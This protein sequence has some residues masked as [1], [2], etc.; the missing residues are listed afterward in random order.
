MEKRMEKLI[1]KENLDNII[2]KLKSENKKIVFTNGCFDILH[3]GH[4]RYLKESKKFG[5]IL[6]V[7]LNSD[8]SV[9]KIK[10]ES[11]PINPEMDRAEVLAGLEAVSY[12]VLFDETSPVKLLEEIKPDIYTKGAD[13]TVETLPEAKTVL[14]YGG[15]IE[16]IKFLEGRSTTK[17]I[18]KIK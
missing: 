3:A 13:Y 5:D 14:S 4:V 1:E 16:F 18:D 7:G 6:I 17:I 2:K 15:K 10:G 12:I 9:K 8:V 11:R